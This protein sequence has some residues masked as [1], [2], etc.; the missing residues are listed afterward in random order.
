MIG[1]NFCPG[2]ELSK[3]VPKYSYM[4]KISLEDLLVSFLDIQTYITQ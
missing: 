2:L 3:P 4:P 1:M